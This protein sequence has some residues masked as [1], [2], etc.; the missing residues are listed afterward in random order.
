VA[1]AAVFF[2]KKPSWTCFVGTEG[3]SNCCY[4]SR[5]I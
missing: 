1:A 2:M 3:Q 4:L 5:V